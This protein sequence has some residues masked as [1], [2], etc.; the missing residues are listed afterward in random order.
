M[1]DG[2]HA[3]RGPATMPMAMNFGFNSGRQMVES[4]LAVLDHA[5]GARGAY[6]HKRWRAAVAHLS[7]A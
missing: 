2:I 7:G 5:A 4:R 3:I 6:V 1:S